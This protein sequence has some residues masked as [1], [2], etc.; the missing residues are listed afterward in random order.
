MSDRTIASGSAEPEGLSAGC[1]TWFVFCRQENL[2]WQGNRNR[3]YVKPNSVAFSTNYFWSNLIYGACPTIFSSIPVLS[4][5]PLAKTWVA[6]IKRR[7][8]FAFVAF[9][10]NGC[11]VA[12]AT[13][14]TRVTKFIARPLYQFILGRSIFL[15]YGSERNRHESPELTF[16]QLFRT[17]SRGQTF[18]S[19]VNDP[20]SSLQ[21][22]HLTESFSSSVIPSPDLRWCSAHTFMHLMCIELPHPYLQ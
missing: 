5:N 4:V 21:N 19:A 12:T 8:I 3:P 22:G 11:S 7:A 9:P 14:S 1:H 18:W 16:K 13:T 10:D 6:K 2:I 17:G 20:K 15:Y